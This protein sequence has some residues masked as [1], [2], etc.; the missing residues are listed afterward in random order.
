[1]IAVGNHQAPRDRPDA[2]LDKAGMMIEH[3]AI[4]AGIAKAGLRPGQAHDVVAAQQLLHPRRAASDGAGARP[5]GRHLTRIG[6]LCSLAVERVNA[7]RPN[8]L[9][10]AA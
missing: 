10:P 7:V 4:D 1:M 3:E 9:M 8:R 2:A 6:I 5:F